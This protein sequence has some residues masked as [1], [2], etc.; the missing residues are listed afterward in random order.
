MGKDYY[1]ILGIDKGA[2]DADIKKA[3]RKM[4]MKYHPDKNKDASAEGKFKEVAEAYDV[5]SDPQKREIFDRYGEEGLKGNGPSPS[6][7]GSSGGAAPGYHYTFQ[8][9]PRDIFSQ[10]MGGDDIINQLFGGSM[11]GM[12]G[13][14]G[15][16]FMGGMGG[17]PGMSGGMGNMN[18]FS[19]GGHPKKKLVHDPAIEKEIAV[20]L[21]ELYK[22][23]VK[24][25][26]ITK[27]VV[28]QNGATKVE[29]K[30]LEI[31]IKPGWKEGTKITFH[32][33]GD[34]KPGHIPADIIFV[35]KQ[36]PHDLYEREGS[37]IVYKH[38]ITL[39]E[40]LLGTEISVPL[41]DGTRERLRLEP[42]ISPQTTRIISG[43]GMPDP[44]SQRRGDFV[45]KFD[46]QFPSR[47]PPEAR[48]FVTR[49]F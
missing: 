18:G 34:E 47:I 27:K 46:I 39:R 30:V 8:G 21:E 37:N 44:K 29:S 23:I 17:M 9:D 36:K 25:I 5:L 16:S 48:E 1:K 19:Q 22:G 6:G 10:F 33:E 45:V 15:S 11:G 28:Q 2:S 43:K 4:A 38:K 32:K 13:M 3:Y 20:S 7:N 26:K 35:V 14:G 40:A 24:K 12:G 31:N 49:Y 41:I 42:I